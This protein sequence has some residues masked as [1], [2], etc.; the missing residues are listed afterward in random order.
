[1]YHYTDLFSPCTRAPL[2]RLQSPFPSKLSVNL[3]SAQSEV[4][5]V[6]HD[7]VCCVTRRVTQQREDILMGSSSIYAGSLEPTI[8][9]RKLR[10]SEV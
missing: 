5:A 4:D 6:R 10:K 2:G 8:R 1:M 9:S 7:R 3:V